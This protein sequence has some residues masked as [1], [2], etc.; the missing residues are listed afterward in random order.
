M[1]HQQLG[2]RNSS[3][4]HSAFSALI[5]HRSRRSAPIPGTLLGPLWGLGLGNAADRRTARLRSG[6]AA[7]STVRRFVLPLRECLQNRAPSP[8]RV[9]HELARRC[10]MQT[11]AVVRAHSNLQKI[12][13]RHRAGSLLAVVTQR[14]ARSYDQL[15]EGAV[16]QRDAFFVSVGRCMHKNEKR[17]EPV[18]E[19]AP[20][21][22]MP[23]KAGGAG[24]LLSVSASF[25]QR[26]PQ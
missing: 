25:L 14:D 19:L 13:F 12:G 6:G 1:L 8:R 3:L 18:H 2:C 16:S 20:L 21:L 10:A 24:E 26:L 5:P 23:C 9:S 22:L 17:S 15:S 4:T 7:P 11:S